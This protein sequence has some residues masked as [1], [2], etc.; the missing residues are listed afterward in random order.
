MS[1]SSLRPEVF[2][3]DVDIAPFMENRAFDLEYVRQFPG[4]ESGAMLGALLRAGGLETVTADVYLRG[5]LRSR[6]AVCASNE[7]TRFT[8]ELL[9]LDHVDPAVCVSVESPI[10]ARDFYKR[11]REASE[12]FRHVFLWKGTRER[13]TGGAE[14]HEVHWPHPNLTPVGTSSSWTQRR[15]LALV[16]SNKRVFAF[17]TPLFQARHPRHSVRMLLPVMRVQWA[18]GRERWFRSELYKERLAAVR[19]FARCEDFDLY[20]HGWDDVSGLHVRDADAVSRAFRGELPPFGKIEV[21]SRYQFAI[22]FENTAFPGYVTEKLFDCL[23]AGCIPV[24]LGAP[25]IEQYIPAEAFVDARRFRNYRELEKCLREMTA[26]EADQRSA[27][28]RTFLG[29]DA[30]NPFRQQCHIEEM[31]AALTGEPV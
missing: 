6:P 30:A 19:H 20:G 10:V 28:A 31:A 14:F 16:N 25:D 22:C 13:A 18:R 24:Y 5:P 9:S 26:E 11:I 29:S 8:D 7:F 17:P 1:A 4:A 23:V 12:R 21:L 3:L 27:A 15:F 2:V